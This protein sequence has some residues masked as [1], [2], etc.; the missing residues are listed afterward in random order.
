MGVTGN[1]FENCVIGSVA[2]PK[3][4]ASEFR[5]KTRPFVRLHPQSGAAAGAPALCTFPVRQGSVKHE[6][7]HEN[8]LTV[9]L[10]TELS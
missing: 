8:K 4:R 1:T 3:F 5:P 7:R 10:R 9:S 2:F 6:S